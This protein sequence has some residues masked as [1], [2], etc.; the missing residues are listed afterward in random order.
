VFHIAA[1]PRP[2]GFDA[3][4]VLSTNL[5]LTFNVVEASLSAGIHNL[6]YASS[7]SVFGFPFF[8]ERP[9]L[10]YL[11]LDDRH[12]TAPQD[13]YALSKWLSEE[14]VEAA[15]RRAPL[16]ATGLRLPWV[17]TAESFWHDIPPRLLADEAWRDLY[18]YIDAR[19]AGA[20]FLAALH[21]NTTGHR[22]VSVA[23]AD[24]Y[25]D[26]SLAAKMSRQFPECRILEAMTGCIETTHAKQA[27]GFTARY[28]WQDYPKL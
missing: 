4:T 8:V 15:C 10:E 17:Q 16:R 25:A 20:A 28:S 19:D 12:P 23:A 18:A 5:A 24:A 11:P 2:L 21:T 1:I 26:V 13:C 6:V 14:V 9:R 7:Y 27:L 3:D 22:R